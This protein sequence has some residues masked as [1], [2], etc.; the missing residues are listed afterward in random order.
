VLENHREDRTRAARARRSSRADAGRRKRAASKRWSTRNFGEYAFLEDSRYASQAKNAR[1]KNSQTV[2]TVSNS[3]L[4]KSAPRAVHPTPP[5]RARRG[6]P[7]AAAGMN[8]DFVPM[9]DRGD[10]GTV[11]NA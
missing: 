9:R 1:G 7:V 8:G 4:G 10:I 3:E 5:Q 2:A 11:V 6:D